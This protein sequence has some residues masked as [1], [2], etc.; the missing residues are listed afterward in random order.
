MNLTTNTV[1]FVA[2]YYFVIP[3]QRLMRNKGIEKL[4]LSY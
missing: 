1:A 4:F 3:T 2:G